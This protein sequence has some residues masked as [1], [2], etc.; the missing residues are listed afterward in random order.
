[1]GTRTTFRMTAIKT[2]STP[3]K[4]ENSG[5]TLYV[6]RKFSFTVTELSSQF[7]DLLHVKLHT[8]L[9]LLSYLPDCCIC[10]L[11]LVLSPLVFHQFL[12]GLLSLNSLSATFLCT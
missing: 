1:M 3:P 4:M 8:H 11:Q 5:H 12:K 9:W 7:L 2:L 10:F 6:F